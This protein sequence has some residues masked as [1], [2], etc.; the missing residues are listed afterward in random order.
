[1]GEPS[2]RYEPD[3]KIDA[4]LAAHGLPSQEIFYNALLFS[5]AERR[6]CTE[7]DPGILKGMIGWGRGIRSLREQLRPMKWRREEPNSLPLVVSPDRKIAITI[8]T[9]DENAGRRGTP[10][11]R[12]KWDKG[13]MLI[14][15]VDPPRQL[16]IDGAETG[17]VAE[18]PE[19]WILL[20]QRTATEVLAELSHPTSVTKDE[21]L[22]FGG[23]RIFL[24]PI[25]IDQTLPYEDEDD[26]DAASPEVSVERL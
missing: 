12:T 18:R 21:C 3:R 17:E 13:K 24:T 22:R 15:W 11:A 14:E 5:E 7:N 1:M 8:A 6:G 20:V 10:F 26:D 23:T 2:P 19:L 4:E 16:S 9:G 25:P